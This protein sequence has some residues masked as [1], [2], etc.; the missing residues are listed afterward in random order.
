MTNSCPSF[1]GWKWKFPFQSGLC[2]VPMVS[3]LL[4]LLERFRTWE[5]ISVEG[6]SDFR[7]CIKLLLFIVASFSFINTTLHAYTLQITLENIYFHVQDDPFKH[8]R[9]QNILNCSPLAQFSEGRGVRLPSFPL[10]RNLQ[11]LYMN[12]FFSLFSRLSSFSSSRDAILSH[13]LYAHMA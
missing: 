10:C 13:R 1:C 5:Q 12:D 8:R 2:A 3:F 4:C 7:I 6:K 9:Q 11:F